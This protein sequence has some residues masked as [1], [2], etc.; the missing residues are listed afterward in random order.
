MS[1]RIG[2]VSAKHTVQVRA[3]RLKD[4]LDRP[5]SFLKIDIEGAEYQVIKDISDH[6]HFVNNL[7]LE[8]HGSFNQNDELNE[9][10]SLIVENGFFL[11]YQRSLLQYMIILLN[12]LRKKH[13][14]YDV[15]LNIFC[16]S[17]LKLLI[18]S[19]QGKCTGSIAGRI[20]PNA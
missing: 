6:L 5:I 1:S 15:Q 8:Y 10:F 12:V 7:F 2:N 16:F 19:V 3:I 13:V 20:S 11:L 4:F 14:D 9:I 17:T 18:D